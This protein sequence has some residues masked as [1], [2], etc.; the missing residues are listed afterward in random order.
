VRQLGYGTEQVKRL[1]RRHRTSEQ[2]RWW[3]RRSKTAEEMAQ[4][5]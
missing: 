3:N 4:N 1:R 5:K 2:L